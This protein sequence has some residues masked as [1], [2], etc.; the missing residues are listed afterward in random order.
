M[1]EGYLFIDEAKVNRHIINHDIGDEDSDSSSSSS[2]DSGY[3]CVVDVLSASLGILNGKTKYKKFLIRNQPLPQEKTYTF[4]TTK[5]N[6]TKAVVKIL[7]GED[8][9]ED[10]DFDARTHILVNKFTLRGLPKRKKGELIIEVNMRINERGILNVTA[11]YQEKG[12]KIQE[13]CQINTKETFSKDEMAE[14]IKFNQ[15]LILRKENDFRYQQLLNDLKSRISTYES[16]GGKNVEQWNRQYDSFMKNQ[17]KTNSEYNNAFN[18]IQMTIDSLDAK[19][20]SLD[21]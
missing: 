14:A 20:K 9:K 5:D 18:N 10:V 13:S 16:K 19:I 6:Q 7:I 2:E 17:P 3:I 12:S 11:T 8:E 15:E 1:A 4:T 21:H